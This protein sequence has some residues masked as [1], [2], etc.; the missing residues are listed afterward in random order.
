MAKAPTQLSREA[1]IEA[2]LA[3]WPSGGLDAIA[4]EPLATRLGTTKG[5][6]YWH[7]KD[8]ADLVIATGLHGSGRRPGTVIELVEPVP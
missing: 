6:F 2:A 8:R 7:F 4:V 5:S 1:W 3:R